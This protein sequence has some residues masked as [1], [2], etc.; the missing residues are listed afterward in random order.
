VIGSGLIGSAFALAAARRGRSVLVL[1]ARADPAHDARCLALSHG[2]R[3]ILERIAGWPRAG[4]LTPIQSIHVSQRGAF[5]R[6]LLS[7]REAHVP[8]LG[9]T[10]SYS[11]L[12]QCLERALQAAG[13]DLLR[14]A[15][16]TQVEADRDASTV[17]FER[18]QETHAMQA[19]VAVLADGGELA[20]TLAAHAHHKYDQCALVATV[21]VD[22]P[23]GERAFERFAPTGAIALL[24]HASGYALIWTTSPA[25]AEWLSELAETPFLAALQSCFGERAGQFVAVRGRCTFPVSLRFL[26]APPIQPRTVLIGNAAQTLHPVAGQGFNLGL[27]D[28]WELAE[29][30]A[31]P[32][33]DPGSQSLLQHFTRARRADRA[34]S[35][36]L[37]D[38]LARAFRSD[39][40]LLRGLRGC[41]LTLLDCAL[42]AKRGFTNRMIFGA[43]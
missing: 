9:Y 12:A 29:R 41:G 39:R 27:R 21:A 3:L 6:T 22:R 43:D 17:R 38:A 19:C 33:A 36:A 24:P 7:A 25:E 26:R 8:A 20:Q 28:A 35:V 11:E 4:A 23:H 1:E 5:G 37:T 16:V 10:V 30:V 18:D 14:S 13:I 40:A 31:D 15:R 32:R 42:P 34:A 2:S